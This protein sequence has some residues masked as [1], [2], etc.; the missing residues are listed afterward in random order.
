MSFF[1][2]ENLFLQHEHA[3]EIYFIQKGCVKLL[4]DLLEGEAEPLMI[5][6]NKYIEGS[7]FGDSDVLADDDNEGRDGT[8]EVDA[9]SIIFVMNRKDLMPILKIFK[10]T[11]AK[12]MRQIAVERRAHHKAAI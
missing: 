4:Y 10:Y 7:Y 9:E 1:S 12:E 2:G 3:E 8:A 11:V 6:F 5:P